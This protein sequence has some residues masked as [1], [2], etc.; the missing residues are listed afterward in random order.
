MAARLRLAQVLAQ[1][2]LEVGGQLANALFVLDAGAAEACHCNL[3]LKALQGKCTIETHAR[4][5]V[6]GIEKCL[7][8]ESHQDAALIGCF[9]PFQSSKFR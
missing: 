3:G 7:P 4:R 6:L 1:P 5:K 8:S 9:G 2:F